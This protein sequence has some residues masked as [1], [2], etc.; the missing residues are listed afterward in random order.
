[1]KK[2]AALIVMA[3][4]CAVSVQGKE[5]TNRLGVGIK[6]N[7]AV[8][9]LPA[10]AAVY[11]PNPDF[12]LTSSLGIDTKKDNSRF[13]FT[14]G[15]RRI[16]FREANMNFYMGGNVGLI[17]HENAGDKDSGFELSAVFGSE[18]FLPGLES[19]G[20]SFEGGLGVVSTGSTRFRTIAESPVQA[21]LVFYF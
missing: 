7:T 17:N 20:F 4:L 18:F 19:L 10:L 11:Y 21:G 6:T 5:L 9:N 3:S 2:I 13:A 16:V 12:G 15:V 1:M 8:D 14:G